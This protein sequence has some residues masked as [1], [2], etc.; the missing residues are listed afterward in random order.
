MLDF[1]KIV[2]F[3]W[4]DGNA[5][6]SVEK[7]TVSQAEAEQIFFN[8]PLLIADDELHSQS[9]PRFHALGHTDEG[10]LLHLTFAVRQS[11]T[12]IRVISARA[13]SRKERAYYEE[14][15]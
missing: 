1:D 13:M 3:E 7:H 15:T 11:D 2:G 14:A 5:R 10:R 4:D 8:E 12:R 9:E 6:K